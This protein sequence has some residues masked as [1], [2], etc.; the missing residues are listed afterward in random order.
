MKYFKS[1]LFTI[2]SKNSTK[3]KKLYGGYLCKLIKLNNVQH[4]V[5]C[6]NYK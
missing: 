3:N 1:G 5:N 4:K 6:A 2:S